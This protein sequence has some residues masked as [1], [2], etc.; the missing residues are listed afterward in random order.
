MSAHGRISQ[1]VQ[2]WPPSRVFIIRGGRLGKFVPEANTTDLLTTDRPQIADGAS[3]GRFVTRIQVWPPSRVSNKVLPEV[4]VPA[5]PRVAEAKPTH[6]K[7][8]SRSCNCSIHALPPSVVWTIWPLLLTAQP[9][10]GS[11][12][13]ISSVRELAI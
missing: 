11:R 5:Q 7:Y 3:G 8:T 4:R 1:A 13:Q 9:T 12:N 2:F 10:W 6:L